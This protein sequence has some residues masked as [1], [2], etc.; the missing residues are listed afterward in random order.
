MSIEVVVVLVTAIVLVIVIAVL[1]RMLAKIIGQQ[2]AAN[3]QTQNRRQPRRKNLG[4]DPELWQ[5]LINL[6]YGDHGAAQRLVDR[7]LR[8]NPSQSLDWG[9]QKAIRDLIYDRSR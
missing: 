1:A 3:P 7:E 2:I 8:N 6:L 9:I 5:Q 4:Y